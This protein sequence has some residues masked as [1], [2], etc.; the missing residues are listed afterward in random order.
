IDIELLSEV[1][2]TLLESMPQELHLNCK[3]NIGH[4]IE[5]LTNITNNIVN[6]IEDADKY[7][8]NYH[9][10]YI[11][12]NTTTYWYYCSQRNTLASK[13]CK[14]LDMSKQRD[15]PSKE[16]FD[17]GGILKIAIN[18]ATQTAKI[19]LYHKNLHAPP[20]NIAVSQNIKD[21]I[22]TNINLLPREIYARL[23]NENL[24]D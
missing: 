18:E 3:I 23:I 19:S 1:V 16:R 5:D 6:L 4:P 13:P 20:I 24:I 22:K 12:R 10:S 9:R 7:N 21:F 11:S 8:W 14:H 17:C 2:M 15:T